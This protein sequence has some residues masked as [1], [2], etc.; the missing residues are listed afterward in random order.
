MSSDLAALKMDFYVYVL[1]HPT[2]GTPCY[3]GKG[4]GRRTED[5]SRRPTNS[6]LKSIIEKTHLP[7]I[8]IKI[9]DGLSESDAFDLEVIFI[10]A[11]GR[12][13]HGG[14]LANMTDGGEGITGARHTDESKGKIRAANLG[15]KWGP[16]FSEKIKAGNTEAVRLVR[17][18]KMKDRK[19]SQQH[20]E[21]I[22]EANFGQ[23]RSDEM[24]KAMS[25]AY[26]RRVAEFGTRKQTE[27]TKAKI[28]AARVAYWAARRAGT[29]SCK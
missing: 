29:S 12:R 2:R 26:H 27:A 9:R 4:R 3:V 6:Y 23:K 21:R 10:A 25:V 24:C 5:Q 28:S 11:I 1:F 19:L 18:Q 20:R 15:K 13:K 17:S 8:C 16:D 7:L 14:T 22:R